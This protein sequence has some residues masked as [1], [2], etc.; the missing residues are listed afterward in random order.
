LQIGRI[1]AFPF[2]S[3]DDPLS[4]TAHAAPPLL[5]VVPP[6]PDPEPLLD[7]LIPLEEP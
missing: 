4:M 2:V 7:G 3:V 1:T 5:L 6:D